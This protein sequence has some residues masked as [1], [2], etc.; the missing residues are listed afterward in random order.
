MLTNSPPKPTEKIH[1]NHEG[2]FYSIENH[3]ELAATMQRFEQSFRVGN[4]DWKNARVK[5]IAG[6]MVPLAASTKLGT[7]GPL[8]SSIL[9]PI[10]RSIQER[11]LYKEK[12]VATKALD[13]DFKDMEMGIF[14]PP[15]IAEDL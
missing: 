7:I 8:S 13:G 15:A 14:S 1:E 9:T 5:D 4:N 2:S 10:F 6:E 12:G 3:C 11:C